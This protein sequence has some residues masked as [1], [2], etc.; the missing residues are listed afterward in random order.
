MGWM[1]RSVQLLV[2]IARGLFLVGW[3]AWFHMKSSKLLCGNLDLLCFHS[4]LGCSVVCF[5]QFHTQLF[6]LKIR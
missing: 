2:S 3:M 1:R 4:W 5:R 6:R